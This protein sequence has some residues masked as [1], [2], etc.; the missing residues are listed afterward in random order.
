VS[1]LGLG[2]IFTCTSHTAY[3]SI[4]SH[5]FLLP[6]SQK[7]IHGVRK[8]SLYCIDLLA[9]I[10]D[11][12][13]VASTNPV[14]LGGEWCTYVTVPDTTSTK[15]TAMNQGSRNELTAGIDLSVPQLTLSFCGAY[16]LSCKTSRPWVYGSSI[17]HSP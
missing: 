16:T 7:N 12:G 11:A 17:Q 5:L 13:P 3:F 9:A 15:Q 14:T 2:I 10:H 1:A 8:L 4:L 6:S